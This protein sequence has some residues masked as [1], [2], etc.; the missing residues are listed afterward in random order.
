MPGEDKTEEPTP[1]RRQQARE[2]GQVAKSQ[3]L[4]QAFLL[5]IAIILLMTLGKELVE[6]LGKYTKHQLGDDA[7]LVGDFDFLMS[8][9]YGAFQE[10]FRRVVLIMVILLVTAVAVNLFQIGWMFLP[11]K[12]A[13]DFSR[14]NPIKGFQNI[15]SLSKF[16]QL[17]FSMLKLPIIVG[18]AFF[19]LYSEVHTVMELTGTDVRQIAAYLIT[20]LLWTALKIAIALLILAILDYMYQYWKHEQDLKMSPDEVKEEM[21]QTYGNPEI[22]GKR[23]NLQREMAMD[24]MGN[25]VPDADV[26]VTNPTELAVALKYDADKMAA[27]VV[28]AKGAGF[29]AQRIRRLALEH[30]VPIVE[31]KPLAQA[32][33]REVEIDQPIPADKYAAVAEVLAYVYQLQG[34]TVPN[35]PGQSAA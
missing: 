26:V 17:G 16:V 35:T 13:F 33:Y 10:F 12:L 28:V 7:W 11:E 22:M 30:G 27:P 2:K 31:K 6:F 18:V 32:L 34:K 15:F 4:A 29:A 24:R 3:D 23:K 8:Q 1:R 25:A 21:K 5:V 9:C 14:L 19:S 20:T